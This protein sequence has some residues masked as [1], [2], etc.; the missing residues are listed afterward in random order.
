MQA[1]RKKRGAALA[2]GD[3]GAFPD[4]AED[5]VALLEE[6]LGTCADRIAIV[7]KQARVEAAEREEDLRARDMEIEGCHAALERA[8]LSLSQRSDEVY[9]LKEEIA[10]L[11]AQASRGTDDTP[12]AVAPPLGGAKKEPGG[13]APASP[14]KKAPGPPP[15]VPRKKQNS[16]LFPKK[17][18]NTARVAPEGL[19][20]GVR[21]S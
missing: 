12:R 5:R 1:Y 6:E 16:G 17:Q 7:K 14:P 15:P 2:G 20:D 19:V 9:K 4:A 10:R 8:T 18:P 13:V 21:Y 11:R 3:G